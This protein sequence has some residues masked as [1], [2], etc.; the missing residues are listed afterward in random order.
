VDPSYA[1]L[2]PFRAKLAERWEPNYPLK[3]GEGLGYIGHPAKAD[4][5]FAEASSRF[6]TEKAFELIE[7]QLLGEKPPKPSMFY[8]AFF[9]RTNFVRFA[10]IAALV[11]ILCVFAVKFFTR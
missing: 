5:K 1:Q 2:K 8:H 3:H 11:A 7:Q 6:L 9:F 4:L 10:A